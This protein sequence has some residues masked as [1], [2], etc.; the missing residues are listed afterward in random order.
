ML[1]EGWAQTLNF[2]T[3]SGFVTIDLAAMTAISQAVAAY[4][5]AC[6]TAE[7]A[8][9]AAIDEGTVTTA[10]QINGWSWP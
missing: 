4:V 5:Q 7:E 3:T 1:K 8:L 10:A 6:F 9:L 2:K